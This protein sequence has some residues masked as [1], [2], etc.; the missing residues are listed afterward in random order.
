MV[1]T[2]YLR[3]SC[4]SFH[5]DPEQSIAQTISSIRSAIEDA[6]VKEM[7]ARPV[8]IVVPPTASGMRSVVR[9]MKITREMVDIMARAFTSDHKPIMRVVFKAMDLRLEGQKLLENEKLEWTPKRDKMVQSNLKKFEEHLME[10]LMILASVKG[11]M[12]MRVHFGH[13]AFKEYTKTFSKGKLSFEG[14]QEMV[15]VPWMETEFDP[16]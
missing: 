6:R 9:P 7:R 11:L 4:P 3:I 15:A 8:Y 16:E 12:R 10:N 14:F 1:G 5:D 2:Q 13:V